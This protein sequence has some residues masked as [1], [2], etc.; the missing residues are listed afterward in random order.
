MCRNFISSSHSKTCKCFLND[1]NLLSVL[2]ALQAFRFKNQEDYKAEITWKFFRTSKSFIIVLIFYSQK[3]LALLF[4][5]KEGK[6]SPDWKMI[7]LLTI[8][9]IIISATTTVSLKLAV[10]RMM[11]AICIFSPK[12]HWLT[13][14]HYIV[15][16]KSHSCLR[17][18]IKG[19]YIMTTTFV[20]CKGN[21]QIK[22][23]VTS[24][25]SSWTVA[26]THLLHS[27]LHKL[28]NPIRE[29][30]QNIN[31]PTGHRQVIF[32]GTWKHTPMLTFKY[33]WLC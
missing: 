21:M 6:F 32:F 24:N 29:I 30:A 17:L 2:Q 18:R 5:L 28:W 33:G 10:S 7:E 22:F 31:T 15:L 16:R 25:F 9:K 4:L 20:Q 23:L 8:D 11:T 26:M 3:K 19:L 1:E 12:W 13:R 27:L 14:K